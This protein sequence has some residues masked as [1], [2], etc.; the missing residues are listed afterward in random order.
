[1]S[2][3]LYLVFSEPPAD[4]PPAEYQRWYETHLRE[5]L[6]TPGFHAGRRFA[7][8]HTVAGGEAAFSHLALYETSGSI[9]ELRAALEKRREA[10]DI[11]LPE[12]FGRIRF[13]SWH[14]RKLDGRVVGAPA[15]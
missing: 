12:W 13:S 1:M 9:A 3:D 14:A 5:N 2:D 15:R 11:V 10:G 6:E 8:D 7:L 4:L